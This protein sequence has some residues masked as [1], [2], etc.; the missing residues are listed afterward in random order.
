MDT[1]RNYLESMFL[2]LPNTPEVRRAKSELGQM[3]EDK[4][5]ELISEGKSENEAIG[6]VI[7]EFGNLDEL[8][9]ELGIEHYLH[10]EFEKAGRVLTLDEVKN[11]LKDKAKCSFYHGMTAFLG[12]IC[13]SGVILAGLLTGLRDAD[14]RISMMLGLGFLFACIG[15]IIALSVYSGYLMDKW[16]FLKRSAWSVDYATIRY[17]DD[18]RESERQV[19][20]LLRTVGVLL[21]SLCFVPLVLIGAFTENDFLSGLGVI[22][23]LFMVAFGT[24]ILTTIDGKEKACKRILRQNDARTIGGHYSDSQSERYSPDPK[25][26]MLQQVYWPTVTCIY[27]IYSFLTFRWFSSWIIWIIAAIIA[28]VIETNL[29]VKLGD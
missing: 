19:N 2:S 4:Y 26:R 1:I 12:I 17:V 29:G 21:C 9:E 24:L 23:L 20:A 13:A 16:K 10:P 8:A 11:Y 27:L 18:L 6:I 14:A 5:N 22:I 7:A 15:G 3:M 25:I 28:K